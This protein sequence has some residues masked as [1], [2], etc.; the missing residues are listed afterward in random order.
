MQVGAATAEAQNS[1]AERGRVKVI[2]YPNGDAPEVERGRSHRVSRVDTGRGSTSVLSVL[3]ASKC[4]P[5]FGPQ[6]R[7]NHL[8][9]K[10]IS[11]TL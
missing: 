1:G 11:T 3:E 6:S 7:E 8:L 4:F 10:W 5:L 2:Y 9:C